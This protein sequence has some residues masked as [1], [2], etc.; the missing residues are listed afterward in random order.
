M[1]VKTRFWPLIRFDVL[2]FCHQ[3]TVVKKVNV[4]YVFTFWHYFN[5]YFLRLTRL[6]KVQKVIF[7]I[8][9]FRNIRIFVKTLI[10]VLCDFLLNI[11][12]QAPKIVSRTYP[13][14]DTMWN[15]VIFFGNFG[16]HFYAIKTIDSRI[17]L[18]EPFAHFFLQKNKFLG[19][20]SRT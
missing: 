12:R 18:F 8:K 14:W 4:L 1:T 13:V 9:C 2:C 3:I 19:Y 17:R 5:K 10:S 15:M 7:Y 6:Q 20:M 11:Y 16:A